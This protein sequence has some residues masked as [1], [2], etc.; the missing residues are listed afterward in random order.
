MFFEGSL[1]NLNAG[2]FAWFSDFFFLE[3]N[4]LMVLS[5]NKCDK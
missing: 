4:I 3:I 1:N 5:E 2:Q